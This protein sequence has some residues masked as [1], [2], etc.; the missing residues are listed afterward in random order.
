MNDLLSLPEF[1]VTEPPQENDTDMMFKVEATNPP[2]C[3]PE[4]GFDKLYKNNSRKQLI[5]DLPI[6]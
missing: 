2:E 4:C 1:T 6:R 3:C 5:M